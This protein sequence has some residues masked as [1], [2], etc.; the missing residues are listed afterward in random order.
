MPFGTARTGSGHSGSWV[1]RESCKEHSWVR[2]LAFASFAWSLAH[3]IEDK[4]GLAA[5]AIS[6]R[7]AQAFD[8]VDP[9]VAQRCRASCSALVGRPRGRRFGGGSAGRVELIQASTSCSYQ[10]RRRLLG[11]LK[12]RGIRCAY[13]AFVAQVRIVVSVFPMRADSCPM[14]RIFG[15]SPDAATGGVD[16]MSA[17]QANALV[18]AVLD[19]A[20]RDE[21]IA[22]SQPV[23]LH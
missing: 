16:G 11:N 15:K 9:A 21:V 19:A 12:G 18:R 20:L 17:S 4:R 5:L 7:T 1:S 3:S 6:A 2:S 10:H 22:A 23:S 8:W 13:L 14:K